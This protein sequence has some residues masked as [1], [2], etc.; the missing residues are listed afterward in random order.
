METVDSRRRSFKGTGAPP[1]ALVVLAQD[2]MVFAMSEVDNF[3]PVLKGWHPFAGGV[4]AA[5]LHSCYSLEFRQYLSSMSQ[6]TL[7]TVAI[8]KAADELEKRLVG[9]A[10]EDAAECDDGGK[11]LIREMPPYE[12]DRAM[13]D[14]TRRWVEENVEKTTQCIDRNIQQEVRFLCALHA[15][16][17]Q[18][19]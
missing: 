5:T 6:M 13:G 11:S 3:S 7:D 18:Y 2:T 10:V 12:A 17:R 9:I 16:C 19:K 1:P 8:L 15:T 14:L 4:A